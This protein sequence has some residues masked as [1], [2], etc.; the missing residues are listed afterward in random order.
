MRA[1][2]F[3]IGWN[4]RSLAGAAISCVAIALCSQ[5]VVASGTSDASAQKLTESFLS[6]PMPPGFRVVV[7]E[8]EGPVFADPNGRTLYVWP[9]SPQRNGFA[10][11]TKGTPVCYGEKTTMTAGLIS[12]YPSG[13]ILPE[14]DKRPSC[15][16]LWPPVLASSES[17]PIGKWTVVARKDGTKQ[18]AYDELPLYTSIRDTKPGDVLGGTTRR[19][20]EGGVKRVPLAAA[21]QKLRDESIDLGAR[22]NVPPGFSIKTTSTGRLLA[23]DGNFSVYMY[24][25]DTANKSM[26]DAV[27]AKNWAPI[28]APDTA[29]AQ[30]EWSILQRS[31]GVKQWMFRQQPLYTN[32]YEVKSGNTWSLEGTDVPGWHVVYTQLAPPP[33]QG[34]TVQ[35]TIVGQVLADHRGLTIYTYACADD[36][37]DQ[38]S[39]D[40]PD[41]TQ[42]YRLAMCGGG[43]A[44]KCLR[45]WPYLIADKNAKGNSAWTVIRIDPK[46]G[47]RAAPDQP[48]ALNVWAY[49]D[50]PVYTYGADAKPGD[51]NGAGTGEVRGG[52]NGLQAFWL[53]DDHFGGTT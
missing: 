44:A 14:L 7:S 16:D 2:K 11:E 22:A 47:H 34:F 5:V 41:D 24:E 23:T 15:T 1:S 6:V 12:P 39:C 33:P 27:C 37:T 52:R 19:G 42:V 17:K 48:D 20:G 9:Y 43:D 4:V 38:L 51:V 50:R 49:R 25:K 28:L 32:E 31:P 13:V 40:H 53:R 26:C 21:R 36:S 10:G 18:W 45:N 29:R 35:D 3:V 30:G 46:T 8:L